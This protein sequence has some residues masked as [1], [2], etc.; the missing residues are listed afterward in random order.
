MVACIYRVCIL[1]LVPYSCTSDVVE[2]KTNCITEHSSTYL[3]VECDVL[4]TICSR[5][6]YAAYVASLYCFHTCMY[7]GSYAF[8]WILS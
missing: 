6:R 8:D 5:Q 1:H 2:I 3:H 4:H 7:K